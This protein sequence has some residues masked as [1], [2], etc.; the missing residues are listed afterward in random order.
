MNFIFFVPVLLFIALFLFERRTIWI[1]FFFILFALYFSALSIVY[2]ESVHFQIGITF[3]L[4]AIILVVLLAPFYIASFVIALI[5]SGIRL[6][7]REGRKFHNFLSI[8]LGLF[9]IGWIIAS[10]FISF[11]EERTFLYSISFFINTLI[12]YFFTVMISFAI[13]SL[14]NRLRNPFKKYNYVI[15]LGSGLINGKVTPLLAS[16]ILKGIDLYKKG[17]EAKTPIKLIFTGGQGSDEPLPEGLAMAQYAYEQNVPKEDVIIEDRA[18]NT[19]QNILYSYQLLQEDWQG[20]KEAH[21]ITVTN[22]Y[23]VFRALLWARK[24]GIKSDGAGS[25]TKFYFWLN[26]LI[27]EYIGVLYM[28]RK[29][30]IAVS[31]LIFILSIALYFITTYYVL[32]FKGT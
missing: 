28:Y 19:Y 20:D 6:I 12:L 2:F 8:G 27:R 17:K 11:P 16:R 22:N 13:A 32:P 29:F 10:F 21:I 1:G 14:L 26:A 30:H 18:V 25:K 23:H 7:K 3:A 4:G 5:T 15:V 9:I 31:I 24:V